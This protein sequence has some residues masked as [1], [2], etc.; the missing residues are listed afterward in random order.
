MSD[1]IS[2]KLIV[3]TSL[4]FYAL[5][6]NTIL[7]RRIVVA[8]CLSGLWHELDFHSDCIGLRSRGH[9]SLKLLF[10]VFSKKISFDVWFIHSSPLFVLTKR[11]L[12]WQNAQ[13]QH[14][15]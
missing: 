2:S 5:Q 3:L 10:I 9:V 6:N 12:L 15:L 14:S 11:P 1:E 4:V 13:N 8:N 7:I